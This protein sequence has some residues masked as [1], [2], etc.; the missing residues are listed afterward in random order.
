[1]SIR[2]MCTYIYIYIFTHIS[3]MWLHCV[4]IYHQHTIST[5]G[6]WSSQLCTSSSGRRC[7]RC[8][9]KPRSSWRSFGSWST[10]TVCEKAP[11][12]GEK[13]P[14]WIENL[15]PKS[16]NS[17]WFILIHLNSLWV[18][19]NE[20]GTSPKSTAYKG[21][22]FLMIWWPLRCIPHF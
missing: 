6:I 3:M 8:S 10:V 18:W 11:V 15:Q 1:M 5:S 14:L 19:L 20:L 12:M 17:S 22:C 16:L 21:S 2:I 7:S 13:T 9:S 4:A